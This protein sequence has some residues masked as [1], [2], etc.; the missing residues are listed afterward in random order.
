[1]SHPGCV[2]RGRRQSYAEGFRRFIIDLCAKHPDVEVV[3][4]ADAIAVPLGTLKDWLPTPTPMPA[5]PTDEEPTGE[6]I[7]APLPWR[8]KSTSCTSNR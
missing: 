3:T 8:V 7:A 2:D 4:M 5:V 6:R 1:M